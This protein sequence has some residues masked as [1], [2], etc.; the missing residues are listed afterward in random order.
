VRMIKP[1]MAESGTVC[2]TDSENWNKKTPLCVVH[3]EDFVSVVGLTAKVGSDKT[4]FS[5]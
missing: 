2:K 4:P 1:T 3:F 5:R